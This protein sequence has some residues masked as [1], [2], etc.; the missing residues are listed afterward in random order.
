MELLADG[1]PRGR[2]GRGMI[3]KEMT[4]AEVLARSPQTETVFFS[5][6]MDCLDCSLAKGESVEDAAA[7]HGIDVEDLIH[8]LNRMAI[9]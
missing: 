7:A 5:L 8:Q 2:G 6:G 9:H 4:I 3:T 1:N